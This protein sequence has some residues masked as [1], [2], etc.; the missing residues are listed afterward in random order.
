MESMKAMLMV[1]SIGTLTVGAFG[2]T[3]GVCKIIGGDESIRPVI[4]LSF[5][6]LACIIASVNIFRANK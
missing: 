4:S 5:G 6:I 2:M 1:I 3:V